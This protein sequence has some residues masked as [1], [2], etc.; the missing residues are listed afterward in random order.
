MNRACRLLLRAVAATFGNGRP[1]APVWLDDIHPPPQRA[2]VAAMRWNASPPNRCASRRQPHEKPPR[3]NGRSVVVRLRLKSAVAG[4]RSW[5][6]SPRGLCLV[7]WPRTPAAPNDQAPT[8]MTTLP[9][10][11][12]STTRDFATVPQLTWMQR[13]RMAWRRFC[14]PTFS[15][16]RPVDDAEST[17]WCNCGRPTRTRAPHR[18]CA[19]LGRRRPRRQ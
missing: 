9:P 8:L 13:R 18:P 5:A 19:P 3:S 6:S 4:W 7:T 2:C 11:R 10:P 14:N 1:G 12:A 17:H 16:T 15:G